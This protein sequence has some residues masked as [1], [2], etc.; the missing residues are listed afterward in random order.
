MG[1]LDMAHVN[2]PLRVIHGYTLSRGRAEDFLDLIAGLSRESLERIGRVPRKRLEVLPIAALVLHRVLLRTRPARLVFTALGLREG[3]LFDRLSPA[4]RRR[5]PLLASAEQM[6]RARARFAVDGH[7][8]HE[9]LTPLFRKSPA[10]HERL[11]LAASL[12]PRLPSYEHPAYRA[13]IP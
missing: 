12:L 3:C 4:Q 11:R 8:L 6:A 5:D 7:S 10:E 13:C 1:G 9:W 2:Y